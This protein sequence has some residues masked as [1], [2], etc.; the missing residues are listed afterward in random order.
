MTNLPPRAIGTSASRLMRLLDGSHY[1]AK[2]SQHEQDMIRYWIESAAPYAGTYASIG[3]GQIGGY[4][5]SQ[6]DT[7]DRKWPES[8]AAA[9]AIGR[10]CTSCHDKTRPMPRYLSDDLGLVLQNPDDNDIRIRWSRHLFFNF[11]RPGKS[12]ALL[13][14]LSAKSGGHGTCIGK[15]GRPI[16]ADAEDADYQKI[17]AMCIAGERHLDRIKRFDMPGFRPL[18]WY[19]RE[20]KRY[21]VLRADWSEGDALDPYALDQA[22]WRS[23]WWR[24]E[25][26]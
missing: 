21:G 7:A 12:L 6:L 11:T 25:R 19:T 24:P 20:M 5:K 16:F 10:R 14:P 17:L 4:P 13:A 3:T 9:E 8:V 18:S 1:D 15:D 2:L 22:Y 23:L 26:P